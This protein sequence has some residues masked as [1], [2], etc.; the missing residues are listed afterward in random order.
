MEMASQTSLSG[1]YC[2]GTEGDRPLRGGE[3]KTT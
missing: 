1:V 3:A 2:G